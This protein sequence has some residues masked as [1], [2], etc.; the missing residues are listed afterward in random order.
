VKLPAGVQVNLLRVIQE[1][2]S[3]ACSS[4]EVPSIATHHSHESRPAAD[5]TAGRFRETSSTASPAVLET[6]PLREREGDVGLLVD[7]SLNS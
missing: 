7:R 3:C 1:K 6:P 2:K 5:V 4:D